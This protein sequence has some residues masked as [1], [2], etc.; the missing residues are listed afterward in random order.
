MS[1]TGL[2]VVAGEASGDQRAARLLEEL[3]GL[4]PHLRPFGMGGEALQAAGLDRIAD[5]GEISVV[6]LFEALEILPRAAEIFDQLLAAVE[7]RR[8]RAALLVDFPEFNLRLA[9]ALAWRGVPVVYYVSPQ[10]WAWRRGRVRTIAEFVHRMLVLF[11]FE[12]PFYAAH[13]VDV[14]HVGH[15]LVEEVPVLEQAWDQLRRGAYPERYRVALLPGSRRSEVEA[16]LPTLLAA[17]RGIAD[18]LPIDVV[19]VRAPTVDAAWLRRQLRGCGLSVEVVG[20]R[21]FETVAGSHLALCA[22]GTATLETGLLGTPMVVCYRLSPLTYALARWLVRVPHVSLVNLV[23]GRRVVPELIQGA[24][25]PDRIAREAIEL[26]DSRTDVDRMRTELG[27]LRER[28]GAPG[29]SARAAAEVARV[30]EG[31]RAA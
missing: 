15:P 1:G 14:V 11:P 31:R 5:S 30:L 21:R 25:R 23:L 27:D 7:R 19:L 17:A 24:A 22:S 6:G 20:D 3:A 9:R 29:A 8:P 10:I 28:L 18:E 16:L 4:V 26:L 13:G 2:L 12:V